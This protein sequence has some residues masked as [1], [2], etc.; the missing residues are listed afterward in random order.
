MPTRLII[1]LLAF[2]ACACTGRS[3]SSTTESTETTEAVATAD[4]GEEARTA[5]AESLYRIVLGIEPDG[6]I[7]PYC[8]SAMLERLAKAYDFDGEGYATWLLRSGAQ[9]GDDATE[10][11][12]ID[13]DADNTVIVSYVDMGNPGMTRL[14]F[15]EEGGAWKVDDA[16]NAAGESVFNAGI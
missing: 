7:T 1:F 3:D 8:T 13:A 12:A 14:H 15:K 9:D 5:V 4:S 6:D 16:T 11:V 10:I 2:A